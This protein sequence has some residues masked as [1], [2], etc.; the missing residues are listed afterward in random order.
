MQTHVSPLKSSSKSRKVDA[1]AKPISQKTPTPVS[2]TENGATSQQHAPNLP[3]H[4][5]GSMLQNVRRTF[6][7]ATGS[8]DD[9]VQT[10]AQS[11]QLSANPHPNQLS[12]ESSPS[13]LAAPAATEPTDST[14][15]IRTT[16][17]KAFKAD[18]SDVN[19]HPNSKQATALGALAYTQGRDI[20]F[21]P[22]QFRPDTAKGRGLIGHEFAHVV[23]QKQGRV[24]PTTRI[25]GLPVNDRPS[26][27]KEA[28]DWGKKIEGIRWAAEKHDWCP[29]TMAQG[30][31]PHPIQRSTG[32]VQMSP[33]FKST[34]FNTSSNGPLNVDTSD[35]TNAVIESADF[36]PS[37]SVR[38]SGSTDADAQKWEVGFIQTI[39]NVQRIGDYKGSVNE[40]RRT[41]HTPVPLRD[42]LVSGGEPWY[43]PNGTNDSATHSGRVQLGGTN[44]TE[45]VHLWDKPVNVIP[46]DSPDGRGKL[47][48][49]RGEDRFV[50]WMVARKTADPTDNPS[51]LRYLNWV[52]W[53]VNYDVSF[54][55]ADQGLK[56]K[57]SQRGKTEKTGSGE[58]K[59]ESTPKLSGTIVN[60]AASKASATKWSK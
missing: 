14:D 48:R 13:Q 11:A 37:G 12:G 56:Q 34:A 23:Q 52:S 2:V 6:E 10:F 16:L 51:L 36:N 26:L 1:Q 38:V 17:G 33:S 55:Y 31:N 40:K 28:D 30:T 27:E 59:G 7:T 43:D 41:L 39:Y 9:N 29:K 19:L 45:N 42:A 54:K 57:R 4:P 32:V 5:W 44:R 47:D 25:A 60:V 3:E 35:A 24:V 46:W 8:T 20:H 49:A 58:G 21:A 15:A 18:F 53:K 50:A 22:G